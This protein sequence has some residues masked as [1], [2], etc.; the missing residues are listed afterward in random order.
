MSQ[1]HQNFL[2][3]KGLILSSNRYIVFQSD[4]SQTK[5]KINKTLREKT[6]HMLKKRR[7]TEDKLQTYAL[8]SCISSTCFQTDQ[9]TLCKTT[10]LYCIY[11]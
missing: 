3:L 2:F 1:I 10:L 11:M 4:T 5:V 7:K 8:F 6:A 9:Q